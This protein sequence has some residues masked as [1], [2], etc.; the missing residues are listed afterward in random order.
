MALQSFASIIQAHARHKGDAPALSYPDGALTYGELDRRSNRRARLLAE[1]GVRKD[2]HVAILLPNGS[3]FHEAVVAVWKSGATPCVLPPKLPGR[4]AADVLALARPAAVIGD[5][6]FAWDGPRIA[7]GASLAGFSDAAVADAGSSHWKAVASGGSSGRPK[8]V[9]DNMPAFVDPA[10][11]PYAALGLAGDGAMLN[12]GPLYHN[13]PFMFTSYG[14]LAGTHVVGMQRLDAEE[15]L[16]LIERHRVSFV[17]FVPTMMQRILALPER[18][19]LSYDLS[20]LKFVWHMAAPCQP[21]VKRAWMDWL[22]AD[23]IF[24]A[25]GGTEGGGGCAI[26]GREWQIGRASCRERVS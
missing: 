23:R 17:V 2:D 5:L 4:E 18:V 20:S 9:V 10:T 21:W 16:R 8:L 13:T 24:E 19:R 6:P 1:L 3:E 25:Y 26:T 11:A 7:Q 14:L 12:P 22:G 15:A